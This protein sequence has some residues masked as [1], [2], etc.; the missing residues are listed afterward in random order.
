MD[1]SVKLKLRFLVGDLDLLER[2]KRYAS[3]LEEGWRVYTYTFLCGTAR[4]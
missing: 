1:Y 3:S 4:G 2:R